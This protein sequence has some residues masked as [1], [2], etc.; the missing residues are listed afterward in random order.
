MAAVHPEIARQEALEKLPLD[1]RQVLALEDIAK[2]LSA[3]VQE[4]KQTQTL[5][6]QIAQGIHSR[7]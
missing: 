5:L 2:S 3:L 6:N 7:R 1:R 4:A